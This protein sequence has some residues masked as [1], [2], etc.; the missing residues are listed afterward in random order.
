[1]TDLAAAGA[2]TVA[3]D[4]SGGASVRLLS[5]ASTPQ[6]TVT[7]PI[8]DNST[9]V[10]CWPPGAL[11]VTGQ[12]GATINEPAEPWLPNPAATLPLTTARTGYWWENWGQT[13]G[14]VA[15]FRVVPRSVD[16]ISQAVIGSGNRDRPDTT[17]V[18]AVGGGWS[19]TD[20]ALPFR[21]QA[22]VDQASILQRG[23][24]QQQDLRNLLE[25][26]TD[27]TAVQ[28]MDLLPQA[29]TRN[30]AFSTMF[31]Q[32][33]LRQATASGAQLPASAAARLIDTR[34]LAG[35]L[36][37]EFQQIRATQ[38]PPVGRPPREILF[39]VEAGITM[40]DLQ[41]LLDHQS[42]RLALQASGG[43]PGATLAGALSTATH[44]AEFRWP[45]LV[46]C[47]RAVHLVGPG[48]L[49]WWIEGDVPVA[50]PA[51]LMALPRYHAIDPGRFIDA[52]WNAIPGLTGQ[53]VLKAV[54]VSMGTMGIIYSVVLAVQPQFGLH[55]IVHPTTW[56][57]VLTAAG[58]T[59]HDLRVGDNAAN[60]AV[61]DVLTGVKDNGTGITAGGNVFANLALNPFPNGDPNQPANHDCW[62]VNRELTAIPDDPNA[63]SPGLGD[64]LTALTRAMTL[65]ATS[66]GVGGKLGGRILDF[67]AYGTGATDI[68]NDIAQAARLAS[69]IT[70]SGDTLGST[71][72]AV[73]MQAVLNMLNASSH[74]DR[75]QA[76][77]ADMLT[78]FVH[79]LEGTGQG[80]NADGTPAPAVNADT[81]GVSYN[82]GAIGWPRGGL[83]GRGLEITL[84]PSNAFSFLQ[85][86]LLDDILLN[87][88]P[89]SNEPLVGYIS[90]RVCPQTQTLMGMQQFSRQSIMIEVVSYRSPQADELMDT[91]Q[92]KALTWSKD[93]T[94]P[95][96]HWG[97]E[98]DQ[99]TGTYL[100]TTPLGQPYKAGLTRLDAFK[101]IRAYLI[102]GNTP[103]F[104]NTFTARLSL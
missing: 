88:M 26:R 46:D 18:K 67:L 62:I 77:L 1:M 16:D 64:Y 83:P 74:P 93:G 21:T 49:Q 30:V 65:R 100:T 38:A 63:A 29:V 102:H 103:V 94:R 61:L 27:S 99:L 96:L 8:S 5:A 54:A 19:F 78:G 6:L 43:S 84:D 53:D 81:T 2:V 101:Q 37:C 52:T 90:I 35:S 24:W 97:L 20:A 60:H 68:P 36:Q 41:Q 48:G 87:I 40:A 72:A 22:E 56:S 76:F 9:V 31:D 32:T 33:N 86:V 50:D 104:D 11:G 45:L 42:P 14:Y 28:P 34:S 69:F 47:V 91:I 75:G 89:A 98:N 85:T 92:R 82:V 44:G 55:Q 25:G 13:F 3:Q 57:D 95:L 66:S 58:V 10:T 12:A 17:P 79:A 7:G 39:Q 71:L 4:I 51:K 59:E 23:R 80:Q 73:N 15:P 70:G